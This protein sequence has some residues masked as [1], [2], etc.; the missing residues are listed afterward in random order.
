MINHFGLDIG[1][2]TIKIVHVSKDGEKF[3][4]LKAG[5]IKNPLVGFV[6]D[7]E[8]DVAPLVEA[9][10]KLKTDAGIS[11]RAVVISLPERAVFTQIIDVPKMTEVELAQAIPWEAESLIPK[12]LSEVNLDWEIIEDEKSEKEGKVKILLV[13]APINLVNSYLKIVKSSGLDPLVMETELLSNVRA[14]KPLISQG[15]A[16]LFNFGLRSADISIIKK[17]NL[18]LTRSLSTSG[19]SATRA[20]SVGLSLEIPVAEEYK[21]TYGLKGE[22]EGKI[23]G[24]I[25][26]VLNIIATE[27]K[28]AIRFYEEKE[29][30]QLKLMVLTGGSALLPG[31]SEFFTSALG[32]EVQIADPLSYLNVDANALLALKKESALYTT[33]IGLAIKEV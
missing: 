3:K 26:P 5:S 20:I 13:A 14:L 18:F 12:P 8:E 19:E 15:S 22:L 10:K 28:K 23:K 30:E 7:V 21:K 32:I 27:I 1:S 25:E 11:T 17:G 33:A 9:I 24:T 2:D 16:I 4:L 31:L 6:S 29:K